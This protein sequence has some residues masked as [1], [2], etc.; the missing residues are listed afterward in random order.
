[1]IHH[2]FAFALFPALFPAP[3]D[4]LP[5]IYEALKRVVLGRDVVAF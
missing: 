5:G 3:N 4:I 2:S 1:M